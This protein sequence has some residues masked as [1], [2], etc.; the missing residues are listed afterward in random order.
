MDETSAL[1]KGTKTGRLALSPHEDI[2]RRW[3][4]M[5]Q[6]AGSYQT[7]NLL[8]LILDYPASRTARS[9]FVSSFFFFFFLM[10]RYF[11]LHSCG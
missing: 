6:K 2:V 4:S 8:I 5:N 11:I 7:L 9:F 10:V 3:L 1:I